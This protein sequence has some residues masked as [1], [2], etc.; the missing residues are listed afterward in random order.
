[1]SEYKIADGQLAEYYR[2]MEDF[3]Q[4]PGWALLM[5]KVDEVIAARANVR[6]ARAD[7][8]Q[9]I[10]GELAQCDWLRNYPFYVATARVQTIVEDNPRMTNEEEDSLWADIEQTKAKVI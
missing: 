10:Q 3:F 4:H 5:E 1:M 6:L 2:V 7:T 9:F 8:L